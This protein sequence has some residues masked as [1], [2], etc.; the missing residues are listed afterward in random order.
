MECVGPCQEGCNGI[1]PTNLEA[2]EYVSVDIR[3]KQSTRT[4]TDKVR[5][6]GPGG[7]RLSARI[8]IP[9]VRKTRGPGET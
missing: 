3:H 9:D 8:I 2:G 5:D 7:P 1:G 4:Q 6:G